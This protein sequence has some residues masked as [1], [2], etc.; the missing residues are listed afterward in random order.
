MGGACRAHD[1]EKYIKK[2]DRKPEGK[3]QFSLLIHV[4]E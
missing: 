1:R 2:F 3:G 4:K